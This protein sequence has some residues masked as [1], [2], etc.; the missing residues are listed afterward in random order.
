MNAWDKLYE[1]SSGQDGKR[2]LIVRVGAYYKFT[3]IIVE[4]SVKLEERNTRTFS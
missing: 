3:R 2:S 1:T 4:I